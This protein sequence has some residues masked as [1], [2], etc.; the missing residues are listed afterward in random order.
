[1]DPLEKLQRLLKTEGQS[2]TAA[3]R[4]VF[5]A[6]L[7]Q[8]PLS[9]RELVERCEGADRASVY[10]TVALFEK[11]GIAQRLQTGWKYKIELA[12]VFH[13]HHHHATCLVCGRTEVLP[14]DSAIERHLRQLAEGV[15][16][17]PER[18][19]VELQGYCRECQGLLQD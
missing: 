8:E 9:M 16:F 4:N 18:H 13:D 17:R 2:L 10:R 7:Y 19:Q 6:L 11:L 5:K 14:E 1:M 12:G 15:A 3:R